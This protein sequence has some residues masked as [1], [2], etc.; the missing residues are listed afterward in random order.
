MKFSRFFKHSVV[1]L[2]VITLSIG[3]KKDN[4]DPDLGLKDRGN[5]SMTVDGKKMN[6]KFTSM[7][8]TYDEAIEEGEKEFEV[9]MTGANIDFSASGDVSS[10]ESIIISLTLPVSKF[11]DPKG[12]YDIGFGDN[13]PVQIVFFKNM[14]Q[15][16]DGL[17]AYA[18]DEFN[19]H[20]KARGKFTVTGFKIG[21]QNYGIY[22]G[23]EDFGEG[24]TELK[25]NFQVTLHKAIQYNTEAQIPETLEINASSF[26]FRLFSLFDFPF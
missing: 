25:G 12:T 18:S 20:K 13:H 1:L 17:I 6:F 21:K 14:E 22:G 8:T 9:I 3:C 11:R 7:M 23:G 15:G 24:Y 5:V 19:D 16:A 10:S 2:F 26:T 4:A